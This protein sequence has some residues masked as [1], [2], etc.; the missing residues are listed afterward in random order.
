MFDQNFKIWLIGQ[1]YDKFEIRAALPP[2]RF[3]NLKARFGSSL[4]TFSLCSV[5]KRDQAEISS[6]V[7]RHPVQ[8]R[9]L[10]WITQILIHGLWISFLVQTSLLKLISF[11][12]SLKIQH[13]CK[14]LNLSKNP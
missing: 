4:I 10:G 11:Q 9:S 6:I 1:N 3:F 14:T 5:G 8:S 2:R 13:F 12:R 7:L